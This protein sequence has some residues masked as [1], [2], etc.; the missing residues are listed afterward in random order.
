MKHLITS[1][2]A[3]LFLALVATESLGQTDQAAEIVITNVRVFDGLSDQLSATTQVLITG[4]KIREIAPNA[5]QSASSD[6]TVIDGGGRVLMPGLN[7]THI[8]ISFASLP[9]AQILF[10]DMTYNHIYMVKDAREVLMRGITTVRDMGGNTFGLKRAIDEGIIPGPRIYPSGA[11]ISQTGQV[12][13][14]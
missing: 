1:L 14:F 6:A 2:L 4:N 10:G 9:Q 3:L 12:L 5:S 8:H 13:A 11:I 7:D